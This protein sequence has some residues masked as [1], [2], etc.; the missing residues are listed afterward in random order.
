MISKKYFVYILQSLSDNTYYTGYTEDVCRRLKQHNLGRSTY[1]KR[2]TP[3][4][5]VY[6]EEYDFIQE[7]KGREKYIKKYGN[8][9]AFL[10]SRVPQNA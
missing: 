5:L 10:K 9:K 8:I 7:A 3:Y 4:K 2:H 6:V 1:T